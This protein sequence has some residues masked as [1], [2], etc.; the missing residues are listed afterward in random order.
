[1]L[2]WL[3]PRRPG[4]AELGG[5]VALKAIAPGLVDKTEA[6]AVRLQLEGADGSWGLMTPYPQR[7]DPSWWSGSFSDELQDGVGDGLDRDRGE[8]QA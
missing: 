4:A 3:S 5:A 6:R 1:V 7:L 2:G 8:Q